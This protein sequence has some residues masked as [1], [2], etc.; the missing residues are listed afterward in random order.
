MSG[1]R[2]RIWTI[3][4]ENAYQE[5]VMRGELLADPGRIDP[6]CLFAY[7]WMTDK[8]N[9]S[10]YTEV[11]APW[12]GWHSWGKQ[13]GRPDLRCDGHMPRGTESRLLE[14]MLDPN[15]ILLSHFEMWLRVLDDELVTQ[16]GSDAPYYSL[17]AK[18]MIY[19]QGHKPSLKEKLA[20]WEQIFDLNFGCVIYWGRH[21]ERWVQ[22]CFPL[23]RLSDVASA[24]P[25]VAR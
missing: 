10:I 11:K 3:C 9:E 20:S 2:I 15:E 8:L 24:K 12:W 16:C 13:N 19:P 5:L 25:F 22:A 14:L 6:E 1:E 4:G 23:L 21:S 17:G 7:R 18:R